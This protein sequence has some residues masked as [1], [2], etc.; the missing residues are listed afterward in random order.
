M[1][2]L[3]GLPHT[4]L[5]PDYS[6]CAF[7]AKAF[8]F[9][10]LMELCGREVTAYWGGSDTGGGRS[11][12]SIVDPEDQVEWFGAAEDVRNDPAGSIEFDAKKDYWQFFNKGVIAAIKE[13]IKPGDI[14]AI[15]GGNIQ[16]SVANAFM[17]DHSIIEPCAGYEG[18]CGGTFVCFES[19][20]WMHY[21]YGRNQISDGRF[22]DVVIP[23]WV[24]IDDFIYGERNSA[25][26]YLLYLGRMTERKGVQLA[27]D[28]AEEA[29]LKIRMAGSGDCIPTGDH[30]EY[31]GPVSR[32]TRAILLSE[33]SALL[34]PTIYVE[35]YGTV[36]VEALVSGC[37]VIT[38]DFGGFTDTDQ[39]YRFRSMAEAIAMASAYGKGLSNTT[40]QRAERARKARARMSDQ[41]I[42][43]KW[44]AW[45]DRIDAVRD[46]R[47]GFYAGTK[48]GQL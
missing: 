35:P 39:T 44:V 20:A 47:N 16:Q 14:V 15:V 11:F 48:R 30:V 1:I 46:G 17:R 24:D 18:I 28:I 27:A 22:M 42:V 43:P 26:P 7:T 3:V 9:L 38:T 8:G 45:L 34:A 5:S 2:H 23:G 29:G 21:I 25:K 41:V 4:Q 40:E 10:T 32:K 37:P 33:A 36:H 6:S 12:V 19:Y 13:R 31:M